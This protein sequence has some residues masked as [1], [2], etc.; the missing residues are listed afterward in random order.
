MKM[1]ELNKVLDQH[2]TWVDTDGLDGK[3]ANLSNADLHNAY[4]HDTDLSKADLSGADLSDVSL[5]Y[6][7][8]C[9]ANLRHAYLRNANLG[10]ANLGSADLRDANLS[11][12]NL[13]YAYLRYAY[14]S[15]T[16]L[17]GANLSGANL[18]GADFS[19][20]DL[21]GANLDYQIEEG[22]IQKIAKAVLYSEKYELNMSNWHTCETTHCVA[23]FATHFAKK[24]KKLEKKCGTEVAGLLLLGPEAHAHF[25][26]SNDDAKA[27]LQSVLNQ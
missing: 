15:N 20:A 9:G 23:G 7:N 3:R 6:A 18:S 16:D 8:L 21:R 27:Y 19:K 11:G 25:F 5:R 26:D 10:G 2:K 14:L 12:A 22:L 1:Q 24:G 13:R 17:R 4:L